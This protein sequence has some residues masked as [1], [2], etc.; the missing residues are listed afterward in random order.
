MIGGL[1]LGFR[2]LALVLAFNAGAGHVLDRGDVVPVGIGAAVGIIA[3]DF[4]F[5]LAYAAERRRQ[6]R[7]AQL[8]L[9]HHEQTMAARAR[10]TRAGHIRLAPPLPGDPDAS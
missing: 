1:R 5:D 6:A 4:G 8:G 3:V 2:V 10:A 7:W 9:A